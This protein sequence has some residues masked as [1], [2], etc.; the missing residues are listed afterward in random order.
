MTEQKSPNL[1]IIT[2][3]HKFDEKLPLQYIKLYL[4]KKAS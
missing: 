3:Y 1:F 2:K 4:A